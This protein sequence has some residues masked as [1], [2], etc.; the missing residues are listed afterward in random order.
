MTY[1]A[2]VTGGG[3]SVNA[4]PDQVFTEFDMRP[5]IEGYIQGNYGD[6]LN[7]A[8]KDKVKEVQVA[9]PNRARIVLKEP[10]P[11]FMAFYGTSATGAIVCRV[12]LFDPTPAELAASVAGLLQ[13]YG[14]V[15]EPL[16]GMMVRKSSVGWNPNLKEYPYDPAKAKQLLADVAKMVDDAKRGARAITP[17]PR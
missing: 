13:V 5:G 16:N 10:W 6:L 3:T 4:I 11:D 14:E 9:G 12:Q 2:S 8:I 7:D 17:Q 1:S 15:A